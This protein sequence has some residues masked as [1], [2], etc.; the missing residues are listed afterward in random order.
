MLHDHVPALVP[1]NNNLLTQQEGFLTE[2]HSNLKWVYR[3]GVFLAL[4]GTLYGAFEIY[5][6]TF[7]ESISAVA[8]RWTTPQRVIQLRRFIV[9]YC[10]LGGLTM[11]WL[12][13]GI[14]GSIVAR[15]TFGSIVSGATA[16]G[17]WCFA[18]LWLDRVRLPA[19]LQMRRA[20]WW[21]V[22]VSGVVMTGLGIR[23]AYDYFFS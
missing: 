8:P 14:A 13:E 16:C 1:A 21:S 5:R 22:F 2:L 11:I 7:V 15:M 9:L 18:M 12:P 3:A 4:M 6:H 17:L 23:S 20:L 10:F 19:P